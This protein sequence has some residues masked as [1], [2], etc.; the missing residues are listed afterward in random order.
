[1]GE[2]NTSERLPNS[3]EHERR[4]NTDGESETQCMQ[5]QVA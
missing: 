5:K 2:E 1:M 4:W 3:L